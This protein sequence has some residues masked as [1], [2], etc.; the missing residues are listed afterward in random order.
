MGGI[1]NAYDFQTQLVKGEGAEARLDAHF[2]GWFEIHPASYTEQRH[3]IDRWF[4]ERASRTRLSVEYKTDWRAA[5][6]GN[7]FIETVSVDTANKPGWAFTS[8][9]DVLLYYC[10]GNGGEQVY[11]IPMARIR[12]RLTRW[13]GRYPQRSIP[14]RDYQTVGLLV[15]LFELERAAQQV[16]SL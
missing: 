14:N 2:A 11:W 4:L 15:P 9:A 16:I 1:L 5:R 3:G 12:E 7:A 10:P 6:T 13:Q 8:E